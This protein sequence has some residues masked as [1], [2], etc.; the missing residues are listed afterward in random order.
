MLINTCLC[1]QTFTHS[2]FLSLPFL[3]LTGACFGELALMYNAP[4]AATVRATEESMAW[5]VDRFTFRRIAQNI[6]EARLDQCA[7]FL[8]NVEL[9][10]PLTK[11][12][13]AKIAEALEEVTFEKGS[14]IFKQGDIGDSLYII[15]DGEVGNA[16]AR[17]MEVRISLF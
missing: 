7:S 10:S 12:E 14:E 2:S 6:G 9:L 1:Y 15:R 5:V 8:A 3:S 13:R 4:R 16:I 11:F 17:S